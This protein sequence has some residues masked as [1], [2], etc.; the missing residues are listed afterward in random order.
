MIGTGLEILY[1]YAFLVTFFVIMYKILPKLHTAIRAFFLYLS[2]FFT[3]AGFSASIGL[4]VENNV[5]QAVIDTMNTVYTTTLWVT[6]FFIF[7]TVIM[8][9]FGLLTNILDQGSRL[10]RLPNFSKK[11]K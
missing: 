7:Y 9:V 8:F 3:L 1:S 11:I 10:R 5:P 2:F 4:A 6:V